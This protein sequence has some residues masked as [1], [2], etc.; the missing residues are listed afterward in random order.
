MAS[1][2]EDAA[3]MAGVALAVL[4]L[5]WYAKHEAEKLAKKAGDALKDI[6][7]YIDP[8]SDKNGA[9]QGASAL[10]R[11][12]TGQ[13][14][15]TLGTIA[16]DIA[17]KAEPDPSGNGYVNYTAAQQEADRRATQQL[18]AGFHGM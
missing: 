1:L 9:Y 2:S 4:G 18:E 14:D 13:N 10:A 11:W 12:L 3:I 16:W 5:A 8:T 17:H 6:A 15:G 7:P